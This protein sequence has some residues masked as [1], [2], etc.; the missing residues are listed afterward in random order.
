MILLARIIKQ[1]RNWLNPKKSTP[2]NYCV[3]RTY[4]V[5]ETIRAGSIYIVGDKKSP[6]LIAFKCPCGCNA[7]IKLNLLKDADPRWD[8]S[9]SA[10][11]SIS[12]FPSVHRITGCKSHFII[13]DSIVKW[14]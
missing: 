12:I 1:I 9:Y 14:C 13:K 8:F 3:L 2:K 11:N 7:D 6:W 5:P 4:D 10:K